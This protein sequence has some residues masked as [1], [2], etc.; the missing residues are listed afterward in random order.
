MTHRV[1]QWSTGN[2]G[3]YALRA[4]IRHPELELVGLVVHSPRKEGMDAGKL[5][6]LDPVGVKATRDVD[7]ALALEADC[8]V[9]TATAD[10]RPLEAVDDVCRILRAGKNVVTSSLVSLVHPGGLGPEVEKRLEE[11][12]RIGQVSFFASGID[13]G[14]ANDVLPLVLSGLSER[15]TQIRIQ[16][17]VNYATYDQPEV[18]LGTMGFGKPLDETPLLLRPGVLAGAWGGTIRLLAAGLGL[19]L[20]EIAQTWECLPAPRDLETGMGTIREGTRAALRFEVQGVVSGEVRLVVEHVTRMH[21]DVAPDWPRSEGGYCV[22]IEGVPRMVCRLDMEDEHGDHAVG[23]VIL[24][25]TRLVNAI[26]AV[27]DAEPRPLSALDLPLVTGRGL[28]GG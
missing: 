12:C 4:A 3:S 27:V 13:P 2:V 10:L 15:W 9:Y 17:I 16:E 18:V 22:I 14:F 1:V 25:A 5:C 19:E 28:L 20:D 11:A 26:P 8:V 23:G 21:D 24:T 6:G 7:A